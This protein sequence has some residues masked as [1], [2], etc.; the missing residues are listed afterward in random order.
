MMILVMLVMILVSLLD[1]MM[2]I[3]M[4]MIIDF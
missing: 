3:G 2:A 4:V 1:R